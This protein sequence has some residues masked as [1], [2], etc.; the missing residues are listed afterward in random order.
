MVIDYDYSF[1][2]IKDSEGQLKEI[3]FMPS[4][5]ETI[6]MALYDYINDEL[7]IHA[8]TNKGFKKTPVIWVSSE[9]AF[10]IKNNKDLRDS[11]GKLILPMITI[12]RTSMVKDPAFKGTFQAHIPQG[13]GLKRD[14]IAAARVINQEKTSNF[15]NAD[16]RRLKGDITRTDGSGLGQSNSNRVNK[17][18]VTQTLTMPLPNYVTL[19]YSIT[20]RT[21]YLQQ[22]NDIVQPFVSRTGNINNFFIKKD[23][24]R[25]E[26]FVESDYNQNNNVS[27]LGEDER[28]YETKV[29]LKILG[30][31]MGEGPN[32]D[33]PKISIT[34]NFVEVKI[35]RERVIVGDVSDYVDGTGNFINYRD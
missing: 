27:N 16:A 22:I 12:E 2:E 15:A 1:T 8:N 10:Q 19:M 6:D 23:G 7:N 21:E 34:E 25:F 24:H 5:L 35:P 33:R 26:G 4:T 31:L 3:V 17:K 30:Y 9:R 32:D 13:P 18:V 14:V 28:I 29:N 11:N 20:L